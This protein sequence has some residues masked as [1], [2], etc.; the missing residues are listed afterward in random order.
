MRDMLSNA[1]S[2]FLILFYKPFKHGDR[3]EVTALA[4]TVN[5]I[6]FR[7]T[8]L[9]TE[10]KRIYVPNSNLFTNPVLVT[11]RKSIAVD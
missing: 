1:L 6:N 3:I 10:G 8:V 11:K 5:D 2:G 7:Y 9:D 4:G